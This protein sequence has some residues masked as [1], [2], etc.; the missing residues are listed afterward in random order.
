MK[1]GKG[2]K[3]GGEDRTLHLQ[4]P[5]TTGRRIKECTRKKCF[6]AT[7][8]PNTLTYPL[9]GKI[10]T[11]LIKNHKLLKDCCLLAHDSEQSGTSLHFIKSRNSHLHCHC[12]E[13]PQTS[14]KNSLFSRP[15][16]GLST[17]Q[18]VH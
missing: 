12:C 16:Q 3:M 18:G 1:I 6:K 11:H 13:T 2:P 14:K 4:G 15:Q 7:I 9:Y 8:F 10:N 17:F 5:D